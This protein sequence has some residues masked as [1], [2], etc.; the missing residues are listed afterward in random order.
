MFNKHWLN[1]KLCTYLGDVF[2]FVEPSSTPRLEDSQDS[3]G[4]F[5]SSSRSRNLLIRAT[6]SPMRRD[7]YT[8]SFHD[9]GWSNWIADSNNHFDWL[10]NFFLG[11]DYALTPI[12][13][14]I[15]AIVPINLQLQLPSKLDLPLEL[16]RT[17][18][19][20]V[21][22]QPIFTARHALELF[23]SSFCSKSGRRPPPKNWV[24]TSLMAH[25]SDRCPNPLSALTLH[26]TGITE[27]IAGK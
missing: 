5:W 13:F 7:V 18:F 12:T 11:Y 9:P 19:L 4:Y 17:I 6:T 25:D 27:T 10:S 24:D 15:R 2:F 16:Q 23:S 14:M 26:K 22:D 8:Q 21:T 20:E 3:H 1:L